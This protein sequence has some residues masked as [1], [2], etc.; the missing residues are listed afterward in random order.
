[1]IFALAAAIATAQVPAAACPDVVTPK[2]FV[3]RALQASKGGNNEAAAQA[4]EQ[5]AG[6]QTADEAEKARMWAAAGNMWIAANQPGKAALALDS[7]FR[8]CLR[9]SAR[10]ARSTSPRLRAQ[11][12]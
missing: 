7:L 1:M 6:A 2:A 5:A 4:F 10:E 11:T 9:L 12:T 8:H 3:C